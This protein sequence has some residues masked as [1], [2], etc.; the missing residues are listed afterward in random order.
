MATFLNLDIENRIN[1]KFFLLHTLFAIFWLSAISILLFRLDLVFSKTLP[2]DY[3]WIIQS[4]PVALFV[5]II[6]TMY[7]LKWYYNLALIF[8]PILITF[9]FL[10]KLILSKGKIYLFSNYLNSIIQF[11]K[12][13]KKNVSR[14]LLFLSVLFLILITDIT[15]IRIIGILVFSYFYFRFLIRYIRKAFNPPSL[16]GTDIESFIDGILISPASKTI[17]ISSIEGLRTSGRQSE[18]E[19]KG[20]KLER[21]YLISF[22]ISSFKDNLIGFNGKKA[23]VIS[24]IYQLIG[25]FIITVAYYTFANYELYQINSHNYITQVPSIFDFFYYTIK[26][27]TFSNIDIITPF[28]V[29]SKI[30]E[31]LSFFTL[32]IFLLIIGV[33]IF[34]TLRQDQLTENVRKATDLCISQNDLI[35][36]YIKEQYKTDLETILKESSNIGSSLKS[37]KQVITKLF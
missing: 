10:P 32:G 5:I 35:I 25:F 3:Q 19:V 18:E 2:S 8:Y 15:A 23:F 16:F 1:W 31:I 37:I 20:K 11:F 21:L 29:L 22:F 36:Q 17:L 26:T 6:L 7:L 34:F 14:L 27:I 28:S 33:S 4:I 12:K 9:W 30:L 13:I 24:W